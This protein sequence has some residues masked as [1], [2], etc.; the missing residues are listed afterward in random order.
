MRTKQDVIMHHYQIASP[1][2]II[3]TTTGKR[4]G[5]RRFSALDTM[6][7]PHISF[8]DAPKD[9]DLY[10]VEEQLHPTIPSIP[11]K[12]SE[13]PPYHCTPTKFSITC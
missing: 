7:N 2:N 10:L 5:K 9:L 1:F 3:D 8:D 12:L 13:T 11:F 4:S 6:E